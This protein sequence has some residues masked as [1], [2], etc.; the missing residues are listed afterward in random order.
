VVQLV[1]RVATRFDPRQLDVLFAGA[2]TRDQTRWHVIDAIAHAPSTLERF[3][4]EPE[5]LARFDT[6]ERLALLTTRCEQAKQRRVLALATKTFAAE[7]DLI[8]VATDAYDK[9]LDRRTRFA[10]VFR[11]WLKKK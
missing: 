8:R 11:A 7:P 6:K 2:K 3:E 10:P 1:L 4:R 9:C 5:L